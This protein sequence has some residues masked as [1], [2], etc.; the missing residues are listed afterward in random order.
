LTIE[1]TASFLASA[2]YTATFVI[3][4][5]NGATQD[6]TQNLVASTF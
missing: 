4:Y 2:S 5:A 1:G 3:T 6:I